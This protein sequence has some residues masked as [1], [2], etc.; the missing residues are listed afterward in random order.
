MIGA[1]EATEMAVEIA[2]GHVKPPP[3]YNKEQ[4][5][6]WDRLL[7]QIREIQAKGGTVDLPSD[8]P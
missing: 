5:D 3:G 1:D 6:Q 4:R 7:R 2:L 8:T